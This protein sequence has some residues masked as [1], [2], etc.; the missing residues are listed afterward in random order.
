MLDFA[1]VIGP[2]TKALG[3]SLVVER[4]LEFAKNILESRLFS[5]QAPAVPDIQQAEDAVRA[6]TLHADLDQD[7]RQVEAAADKPDKQRELSKRQAQF[8][9]QLAKTTD[10]KKRAELL[11]RHAALAGEWDERV[12]Q[13]TVL[14]E[15]AKDPDDGWMLRTFVIQLLG[16]AAGIV[17]ARVTDAQLFS[18]LLTGVGRHIEP[19]QD[20]L[21]TGLFIGGGSGP[22]H[23]LIRFVTERK[24]VVTEAIA[25]AEGAPAA[26]ATGPASAPPATAPAILTP[27]AMPADWIDIPYEGGVDR[28]L[29][30]N[31]H[32]R[33]DRPNLIVYHHTAMNSASPF[34][35]IVK[36]IKGRGFL[37]AYHCVV[38]PDGSVRPFCRWDRFGSHAKDYNLR[39]L[40]IAFHG[41]FESDPRVPDAN[42]DGRLG[43]LQPSDVQL[44]AGA[45]VV[46]LWTFLYGIPVDFPHAIIPHKQIAP[47]ACPGS[48]FPYDEFKR[49][50]ERLRSAWEHA[51]AVLERIEAF[52]RKPY[53]QA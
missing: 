49:R 34:D 30:E 10:P 53:L 33:K 1:L 23:L 46:A 40:G 2:L 27:A 42:P 15:P 14:V 26:P 35:D 44:S 19:Y 7:A 9:D 51:P 48:Q 11:Q 29:L 12:P 21:L 28:E 38:M 47:K 25:A 17:L 20:Y 16:V 52:K 5:L 24:Q 8:A 22:V 36:V 39:S 37:T 41:N 43:P 50:V 4:G 32:R 45:C 13:E 3:L 31:V 6:L 18:A